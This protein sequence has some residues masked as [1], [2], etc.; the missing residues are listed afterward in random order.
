MTAL[1]PLFSLRLPFFLRSL[2]S[3]LRLATV[4]ATLVIS[5][6]VPAQS[7]TLDAVLRDMLASNP[8][9]AA[10]ARQV[11]AQNE[12][13]PQALSAFLP[14]ATLRGGIGRTELRYSGETSLAEND[15]DV[16]TQTIELEARLNLFRSGADAATLRAQG[17]RADE[18]L[19]AY[20][21]LR[22]ELL[23]ETAAVYLDL[24]LTARTVTWREVNRT[25]IAGR[26][27]ITRRRQEVG[28]STLG[29]LEQVRA[30][31]ALA[32]AELV[33]AEGRKAVAV[34]VFEQLVGRPP[35][36]LEDV[37]P[38]PGLPASLEE[39]LA[40]AAVGNRVLRAASRA[41]DAAEE[42][43]KA[44]L[45]RIGPSLDA[46]ARWER[47]F[48]DTRTYTTNIVTGDPNR[49]S[50]RGEFTIGLQA[51]LPLYTG[52]L[53]GARVRQAR[54]EAA[55]LGLLRAASRRAVERGVVSAWRSLLA[56][57]ERRRS[58]D[59]AVEA[60]VTAERNVEQEVEVGRRLVVDLL[61]AKAELIDSR[62]LR[63]RA[64][65]D[66]IY[67]SYAL[68]R[69]T[70]DLGSGISGGEDSVGNL[71]DHRRR[72]DRAVAPAIFELGR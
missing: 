56:S 35:G 23:V 36:V 38:P 37:P 4:V 29:D 30:R 68:L 59:R 57:R 21:D 7:E 2:P 3:L 72:A 71:R 39:A 52:G 55:H 18:A 51:E 34:A 48:L 26:L 46:L 14:S 60:L 5:L 10:A 53:Q 33:D 20:E 19:D 16:G 27:E 66:E 1:R 15:I 22:Q 24:D 40:R 12:A 58:L 69:L 42:R 11:R 45:R 65:R 32:D 31:L 70:G 64:A 54:E 67:W 8:T 9:L 44:A 25:A 13:I 28:V 49:D 41:A 61:D 17:L 43:R 6:A 50:R 63:R 62:V 47:R